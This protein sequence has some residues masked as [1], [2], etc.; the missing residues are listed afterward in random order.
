MPASRR[1]YPFKT[2]CSLVKNL[3]TALIGFFLLFAAS[4]VSGANEIRLATQIEPGL[5]DKGIPYINCA[6]A[7][8][9]RSFS[10]VWVP[11]ER[12]QIGTEEGAY[13]GFFMASKN[14]KRD[15]Y[16]VFSRPFQQIEWLFVVKKG[17]EITPGDADFRDRKFAANTGSAR[18]IWLTEKFENKE[19]SREI[20]GTTSPLTSVR[21]VYLGRADVALV[22]DSDLE[23]VFKKSDLSPSGFN[24]FYSKVKPIGIYFGKAFLKE[25]PAFLGEFNESMRSCEDG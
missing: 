6:M 5:A 20:V 18:H 24:V 1:I 16:A 4:P 21:M 19:F 15:Q 25:E 23:A 3:H 11:W 13:D 17:S 8:M 10:V 7:K 12:A 2:A 9:G 14:C 22:N